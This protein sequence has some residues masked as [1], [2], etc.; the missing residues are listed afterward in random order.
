MC[1]TMPQIG[2]HRF[3]LWFMLL[4]GVLILLPN[5]LRAQLLG[6]DRYELRLVP[7]LWYNSVDGIRAGVRFRGEDPR[8]FLDGPHRLSAGIWL[9]TRFPD[10]P[11]SYRVSYTHPIAFISDDLGEGS[12]RLN[13][14]IR[15]GIYWHEAGI[16]KRWQ[17]GFDEF[18]S[19]D[20]ILMAGFY[21]RF[22][23]A[24]LIWSSQWQDDPIIYVRPHFRMRG[25]NRM[26]RSTLRISATGGWNPSRESLHQD[27]AGNVADHPGLLGADGLFSKA[28]AEL[29]QQ[30]HL[31]Y[32]FFVRTRL[33]G[34]WASDSTPPEQR[35]YPSQAP[36]FD[37][38]ESGW[39]RASGTLPSQWFR[40]GWIHVPGSAGLRGYTGKTSRLLESGKAAWIQHSLAI[41][42]DIGFPNP[43]SMW[44]K[45]RQWVGEF[46]RF[47]SYLLIDAGWVF[48]TEDEN[49]LLWSSGAG[50]MLSLNIPDY[51]GQD[52]GFFLRYEI[53]AWVS[54]PADQEPVLKYR[55]LL[56]L[57]A[58]FH[59]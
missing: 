20:L 33:F 6:S 54:D 38:I 41:N 51:L 7:D 23:D 42:A 56:G 2:S 55:H 3:L 13:S 9:A 32:G 44:L 45:N 48:E 39:T 34:G 27:Y 19:Y 15:T 25:R 12:L 49:S 24:Y 26:G 58:Q 52:R 22:D 5:A 14:T 46:V 28:S 10:D 21:Q 31:R 47:E 1:H 59:F 18:V 37:W 4:F 29:L 17:P 8:T 40:S 16:Q 50:V 43:L 35:F 30:A 11:V 57:G 53:P 36:A